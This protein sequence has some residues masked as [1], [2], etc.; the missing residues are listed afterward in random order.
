MS[1]NGIYLRQVRQAIE[2]IVGPLRHLLRPADHL[3][4][5]AQQPRRPIRV[6]RRAAAIRHRAPRA[7]PVGAAVVAMT[8]KQCDW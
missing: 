3:R 5:A 1:N 4:L 7:S 2:R 8:H 6:R